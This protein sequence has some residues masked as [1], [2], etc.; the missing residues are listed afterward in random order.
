MDIIVYD[1]VPPVDLQVGQHRLQR[2]PDRRGWWRC[3][4]GRS[5][6]GHTAGLPVC[7]VQRPAAAGGRPPP[8]ATQANR[9]LLREERVVSRVGSSSRPASFRS[10]RDRGAELDGSQPAVILRGKR[11]VED[12][13]PVEG[14]KEQ[15]ESLAVTRKDGKWLLTDPVH[16]K[17]FRHEA[18]EETDRPARRGPDEAKTGRCRRPIDPLGPRAWRGW[19]AWP[20]RRTE[21]PRRGAATPAQGLTPHRP[22]P[23]HAPRNHRNSSRASALGQRV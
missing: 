14:R 20:S 12:G 2:R 4:P 18:A 21:D 11:R 3:S 7:E 19:T 6:G 9:G 10:L 13:K 22:R 15:T 5:G 16:G 8:T 17:Y 23:T 1:G